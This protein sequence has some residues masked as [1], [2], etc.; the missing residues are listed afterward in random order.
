MN[1]LILSYLAALVAFLLGDALWL[2]FVARDLYA[3]E[4]GPLLLDSPNWTVAA[5][6]YAAYVAGV[7]R[8]AVWPNRNAGTGR[9]T[10]TAAALLGALAYGT[11]DL[12]NLA[13]LKGFTA[14]VAVV[15]MLWGVAITT[16]TAL[17]GYAAARHK[18]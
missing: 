2:G 8:F 6:F 9:P 1:R 12:T 14:T 7:M 17:A 3:R 13:T 5:V 10:A 18:R 11:Y 4:I 15:D 16:V